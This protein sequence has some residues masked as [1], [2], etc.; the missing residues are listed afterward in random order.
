MYKPVDKFPDLPSIERRV[1]AFW[2]ETDAFEKLRAKNRGHQKW[3]F[4]DGP[5]T[6]RDGPISTA[7]APPLAQF[8]L[9]TVSGQIVPQLLDTTTGLYHTLSILNQGGGELTLQLSD[10]GY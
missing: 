3:S 5:I 4:L 8:R 7:S 1:L 9:Y 10:Q 2:K 6:V